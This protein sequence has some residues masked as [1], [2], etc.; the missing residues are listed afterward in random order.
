MMIIKFFY[1]S[2]LTQSTMHSALDNPIHTFSLCIWQGFSNLF[3]CS[4][5]NLNCPC[6]FFIN[7]CSLTTEADNFLLQ[8]KLNTAPVFIHFPAKG[9][10]KK[11]DTFEVHRHGFDAEVMSRFVTERTG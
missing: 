3:F 11:G 2:S 10:P 9:K 1:S 8:M 4:Q 7:A 6:R 5:I